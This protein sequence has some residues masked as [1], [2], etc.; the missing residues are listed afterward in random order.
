[1]EKKNR[2]KNKEIN[3]KLVL[4]F[5]NSIRTQFPFMLFIY[6]LFTHT[7]VNY[8]KDFLHTFTYNSY[9]L[10]ICMFI[11]V[12]MRFPASMHMPPSWPYPAAYADAGFF[13]FFTIFS[14]DIFSA[15]CSYIFIC[16]HG[17]KYENMIFSFYFTVIF[18]NI[19]PH[20][21]TFFVFFFT[22]VC[23]FFCGLIS[24]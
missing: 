24:S 2:E 18:S 22:C 7:L 9:F 8:K 21:W 11:C 4:Q 13:R 16:P 5:F 20:T 14:V 1:M 15:L 17:N 3:Y 6:F 19:S 23:V 12:C 10:H